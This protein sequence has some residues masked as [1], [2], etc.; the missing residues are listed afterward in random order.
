MKYLLPLFSLLLAGCITL[1]NETPWF[2]DY[3]SK[4]V[5]EKPAVEKKCPI[6]RIHWNLNQP[7]VTPKGTKVEVTPKPGC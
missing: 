6:G 1:S 5:V 3:A 4:D 7:I 2:L